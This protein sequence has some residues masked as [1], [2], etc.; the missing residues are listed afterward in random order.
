MNVRF[1][2]LLTSVLLPALAACQTV[3]ETDKRFTRTYLAQ[4]VDGDVSYFD[5]RWKGNR[6][7]GPIGS[8]SRNFRNFI[9]RFKNGVAAYLRGQPLNWRYESFEISLSLDGKVSIDG[10]YW[11][12]QTKYI[13]M[14]GYVGRDVKDS[15]KEI[16]IAGG[17]RGPQLCQMVLRRPMP[18]TTTSEDYAKPTSEDYAKLPAVQINNAEAGEIVTLKTRPLV[19]QSF[20]F[21]KVA[22]PRA[23]VISFKGGEGV[24][25]LVR[26]GSYK[27][28]GRSA[29]FVKILSHALANKG[30]ALAAVDTP[31]DRR[32]E[33]EPSFR[34]TMKHVRDIERV[35][36]YVRQE[37]NAPV[38][39]VGGSRGSTSATYV[40][41]NSNEPVDGLVLFSSITARQALPV[42][43]MGLEKIKVP[44][45]A[46]AH[47][48]DKCQSTPPSGAQEIVRLAINTPV[49]EAKYFKGGNPETGRR[50]P[51]RGGHHGFE[52]IRVE[53]SEFIADFI[54]RNSKPEK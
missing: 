41:I 51:C 43:S 42:T 48:D 36:A 5:G 32:D 45:L 44:I 47:R 28:L 23:V 35:I 49:S 13:S 3:S 31:S 40:A 26:K 53:V 6:Y 33:M 18:G 2:L 54:S 37:T 24:F 10:E 38:W 52:G 25:N 19:T 30:I 21:L 11:A 14:S 9:L 34:R 1:S 46:L 29:R 20:I 4:A 15:S 8:S 22:D 7:C 16:L 39:L 27:G 17:S 12:K 50:G